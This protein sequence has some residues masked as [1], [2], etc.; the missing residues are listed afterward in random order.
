M[1]IVLWIYADASLHIEKP[2]AK[3]ESWYIQSPQDCFLRGVISFH[4]ILL[5]TCSGW[6]TWPLLSWWE[7]CEV[8]EAKRKN[9][10]KLHVIFATGP[11]GTTTRPISMRGHD[12]AMPLL[13]SLHP[14]CHL[15]FLVPFESHT[16]CNWTQRGSR[17]LI[18]GLAFPKGSL[19][20]MWAKYFWVHG[21]GCIIWSTG[22][23]LHLHLSTLALMLEHLYRSEPSLQYAYCEGVF[24]QQTFGPAN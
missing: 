12:G 19:D 6:Y 3:K 16:A 24:P 22:S 14:L 7:P 18:S 10:L 11:P 2:P 21:T 23:L 8:G 5:L 17:F 15:W 1:C 9:W 20:R 13:S 4:P